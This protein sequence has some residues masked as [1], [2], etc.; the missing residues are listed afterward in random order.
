[1]GKEK[2]IPI[3]EGY[4]V[5]DEPLYIEEYMF[6]KGYATAK[7]LSNTLKALPLARKIHDGKYR[8]GTVVV[9]GTVRRLPYLLH[10][11]K[12]TN[13]LI[14]LSLPMTDEELDILLAGGLLHDALEDDEGYLSHGGRDIV[15]E[16]GISEEVFSIISLLSKRPGATEAELN[17]YFNAIKMNKYTLLIKMADRGHNVEDLY[18]M[19]PER[20]HRY[21]KETRDYVYPLSTYAKAHYP[22][23]SNGV[24]ILK[25][26][27]VSLTE[28]TETLVNMYEAVIAEMKQTGKDESA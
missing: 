10:V 21:I 7:G 22:E 13:T 25:S 12:V 2:L 15:T 16:Y 4:N 1:M 28:L 19:K 17:H 3:V 27:I 11:L 26:K 9:N 23:L 14:S 18:N 8:K 5:E 20:L 6:I 24:T